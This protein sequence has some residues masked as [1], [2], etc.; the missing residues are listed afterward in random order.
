MKASR[1]SDL[2]I[3]N[4]QNMNKKE[5]QEIRPAIAG[6]QKGGVNHK[7]PDGFCARYEKEI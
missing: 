1:L 7:R 5:L 2:L 6:F 4:T 3:D